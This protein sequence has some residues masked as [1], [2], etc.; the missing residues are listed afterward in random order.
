MVYLSLW[1]G[2]SQAHSNK[3]VKCCCGDQRLP[4]LLN[5]SNS[6]IIKLSKK[7][8]LSLIQTNIILEIFFVDGSAGE[9]V[10]PA[11]TAAQVNAE[12]MEGKDLYKFS[13]SDYEVGK[14]KLII[15]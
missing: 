5:L 15:L 1:E 10:N 13:H 3:G 11:K 4:K 7:T 14:S 9:M 2:L 8:V 6:L 12:S